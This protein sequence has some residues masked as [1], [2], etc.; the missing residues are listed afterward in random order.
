MDGNREV[1]IRY[2]QSG[3]LDIAPVKFPRGTSAGATCEYW[4]IGVLS[5]TLTISALPGTYYLQ[6]A[7]RA[8]RKRDRKPTLSA[9]ANFYLPNLLTCSIRRALPMSEDQK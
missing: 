8:T 6:G 3:P 2:E 7:E 9:A 4:L 5:A 1:E